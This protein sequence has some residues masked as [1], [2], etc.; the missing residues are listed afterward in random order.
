M[1]FDFENY[2]QNDVEIIKKQLKTGDVS[3]SGIYK[4]CSHGFPQVMFLHPIR[5]VNEKSL[6]NYEAVSNIM[7]LTCPYLNNK[8]HEIENASWLKKIREIIQKDDEFKS[9]M[10]AANANYYFLRS[11]VFRKYAESMLTQ[12]GINLSKS[13]I[14]GI[15]DLESLKC[16]HLHFCHFCQC[17]DNIAGRFTYHLL[18]KKTECD[19]CY[20]GK[21]TNNISEAE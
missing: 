5:K 4:R 20:C 13:G 14:G 2:T 15:R 3:I 10:L 18:D 9:L 19:D 12:E 8:I 1:A 16:L 7:W 6:L 17:P 21:F 11:I